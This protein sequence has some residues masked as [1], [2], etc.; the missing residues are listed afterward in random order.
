MATGVYSDF[1]NATDI[2]SVMSD[3]SNSDEDEVRFFFIIMT[4][5]TGILKY[6]FSL[7]ANVQSIE[8]KSF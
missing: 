3:G 1:S 4:L 2:L 6:R 7:W 8:V 5:F